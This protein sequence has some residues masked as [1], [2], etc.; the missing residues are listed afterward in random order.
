M[1]ASNQTDNL[2]ELFIELV[3]KVAFLH[4]A[5]DS[6]YTAP[7]IWIPINIHSSPEIF[8]HIL[9]RITFAS[10]ITLGFDPTVHE[11]KNKTRNIKVTLV[12]GGKGVININKLLF[13]SG[14]LHDCG[15]TI[16]SGHLT[17]SGV[18]DEVVVKD[19]FVDPLH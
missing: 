12:D 6:R 11:V 15:M 14:S 5:Q 18:N 2:K 10:H 13:I 7:Y 4:Q 8:L 19:S 9:L 3:G 1:K 17:W 16:W